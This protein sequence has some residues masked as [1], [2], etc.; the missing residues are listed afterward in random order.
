MQLDKKQISA[1]ELNWHKRN[2]SVLS[3]KTVDKCAIYNGGTEED[4]QMFIMTFT[5]G[6]FICLGV[7]YDDDRRVHYLENNWVCYQNDLDS[8]IAEFHAAECNDGV[9][10]MDAYGELLRTFGFIEITDEQAAEVIDKIRKDEEEREY[11]VYL[12]LK[13]KFEGKEGQ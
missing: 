12:K 10:R 8:I 1:Y 9:V 3:G 6:T 13:E 4:D 7:E 5:D 2:P 11:K